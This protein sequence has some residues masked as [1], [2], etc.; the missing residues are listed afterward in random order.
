MTVR[1]MWTAVEPER[2][3]RGTPPAFAPLPSPG[4][5]GEHTTVI[6]ES[7]S[8]SLPPGPRRDLAYAVLRIPRLG[9]TVPVAE[10]VG[11]AGVRD[12]G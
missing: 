12:K 11:K 3:W 10:G 4:M 7:P 1:L 8:E 2:E 5:R 6:E 9:V